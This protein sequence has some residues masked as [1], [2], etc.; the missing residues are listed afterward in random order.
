MLFELGAAWGLKRLVIPM[1]GPDVAYQ[2]LPASLATYPCIS[3][4]EPETKVRA[5]IEDA[6]AQ[7]AK[8][9]GVSRKNGGRQSKGG[10]G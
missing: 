2:E 6:V 1:L 3:I 8:A 10:W 5:R 7:I 4:N 9:T